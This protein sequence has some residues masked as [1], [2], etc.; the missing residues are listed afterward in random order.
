MARGAGRQTARAARPAP[1]SLRPPRP[2]SNSQTVTSHGPAPYPPPRLWQAALVAPASRRPLPGIRPGPGRRQATRMNTDGASRLTDG[3]RMARA[4]APLLDRG[5]PR[6][7]LFLFHHEGTKNAKNSLWTL[8][9]PRDPGSCASRAKARIM[10]E[11]RPLRTW[12]DQ[13]GHFVS[14]APSWSI[15]QAAAPT[16]PVCGRGRRRSQSG[17]QSIARGP[18]A[19]VRRGAPSV[20]IRVARPSPP[21]I[22][23]AAG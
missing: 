2:T 4:S 22:P 5:R 11:R 13:T 16:T 20:F 7:L 15:S 12:R 10:I 8:W 19:S 3:P 21:P 1:G 9:I 18:T 6:P 23:P 17:C 14:F